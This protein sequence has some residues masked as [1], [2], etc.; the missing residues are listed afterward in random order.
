[1]NGPVVDGPDPVNWNNEIV[2]AEPVGAVVPPDPAV[3]CAREPEEQA[4]TDRYEHCQADRDDPHAADL[5]SRRWAATCGPAVTGDSAIRRGASIGLGPAIVR[6]VQILE[7]LTNRSSL[8]RLAGNL[9][10]R[11]RARAATV[12]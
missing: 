3:E 9:D 5:A 7:R 12:L 6:G 2:V 1:M 4:E 10:S 8:S 11:Y